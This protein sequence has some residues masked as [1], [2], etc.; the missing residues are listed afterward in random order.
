MH[1]W[2]IDYYD[3]VREMNMLYCLGIECYHI[4]ISLLLFH[5]WGNRSKKCTVRVLS[6]M[7]LFCLE[8]WI[9]C[10]VG[11]DTISNIRSRIQDSTTDGYVQVRLQYLFDILTLKSSILLLLH[12]YY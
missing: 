4:V 9:C 7:I 8:K 5:S 3:F 10:T 6:I 12:V 1:S 11:M 2:G